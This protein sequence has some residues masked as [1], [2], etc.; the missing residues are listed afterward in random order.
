MIL[1]ACELGFDL[2]WQK[3]KVFV[4]FMVISSCLVFQYKTEGTSLAG[5]ALSWWRFCSRPQSDLCYSSAISHIPQMKKI[6]SDSR[7]LYLNNADYLII[8]ISIWRNNTKLKRGIDTID[9]FSLDSTEN[10]GLEFEV[11]ER[12]VCALL[13][14]QGLL[15]FPGSASGRTAKCFFVPD[16]FWS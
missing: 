12:E 2:F 14:Q 11:C 4:K 8:I 5:T 1:V 7:L 9:C 3:M 13:P 10:L 16:N 6:Y 15:T